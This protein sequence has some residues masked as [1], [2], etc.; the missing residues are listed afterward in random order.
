[1]KRVL[2]IV[3]IVVL[4]LAFV[5]LAEIADTSHNRRI[6]TPQERAAIQQTVWAHQGQ[7]ETEERKHMAEVVKRT[8]SDTRFQAHRVHEAD[9]K[10]V[11]GD[12]EDNDYWFT[13]GKDGSKGI[14]EAQKADAVL[15]PP[16]RTRIMPK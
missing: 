8:R 1:M 15:N 11:E 13:G 3:A 2:S 7:Q 4:L 6:A 12:V 14:K 16:G 9:G 5:K 10:V